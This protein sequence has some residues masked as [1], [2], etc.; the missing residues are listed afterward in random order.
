M[1]LI[2][3]LCEELGPANTEHSCWPD[4]AAHGL[5]SEPNTHSL[6]Q[7]SWVCPCCQ[8]LKLLHRWPKRLSYWI[9]VSLRQ[10]RKEPNSFAT[11]EQFTHPW[12]C[13]LRWFDGLIARNKGRKWSIL[14]RLLFITG[15]IQNNPPCQSSPCNTEHYFQAKIVPKLWIPKKKKLSWNLS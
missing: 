2:Q 10:S 6:L 1:E 15:K 4:A 7:Q 3:G 13:R 12:S 5:P 11:A 9:M 14:R 8:H